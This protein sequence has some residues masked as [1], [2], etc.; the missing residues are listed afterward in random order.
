MKRKNFFLLPIYIIILASLITSCE[1]SGYYD[2]GEQSIVDELTNKDWERDYDDTHEIFHFK[3]DGTC[4][5]KGYPKGTNGESNVW[6][7]TVRW[8]F[9]TT[10][11]RVI[12]FTSDVYCQLRTLTPQKLSVTETWGDYTDPDQ[13]RYYK[14]FEAGTGK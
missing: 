14:D 9:V 13:T 4:I 2:E 3:K 11:F 12:Y 10:D 5:Q 8:A 6:E 1:R 7:N